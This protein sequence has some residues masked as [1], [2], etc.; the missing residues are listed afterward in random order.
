[1]KI[2][3]LDID[4]VL[5]GINTGFIKFNPE[6]LEALK[7]ILTETKASV[8]LSSSWRHGYI[9]WYL[10]KIIN[11][12]DAA[13]HLMEMLSTHGVNVNIVDIT[14]TLHGEGDMRGS[15]IDKWIV[16][17]KEEYNIESFVILD[18][19]SDMFPH[20]DRLVHT[21]NR[22]GLTMQDAE[23]AIKKLNELC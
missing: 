3:F 9:D 16:E 13:M 22:I 12:D 19:D 8:V 10:R 6:S 5:N 23:V 4:G 1:M 21:N 7:L 15:E 17:N 2:V 14:P 18:D 20:M 11:S